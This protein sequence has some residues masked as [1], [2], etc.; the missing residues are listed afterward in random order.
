M[1][2]LIK[3]LV[4]L[5]ETQKAP[6][7]NV[8]VLPHPGQ[9]NSAHV[10]HA[11]LERPHH[12]IETVAVLFS[13]I[14]LEVLQEVCTHRNKS[15]FGPWQKPIDVHG[16]ENRREHLR[17]QR[18]V[19]SQMRE[20]QHHV[21]VVS[22]SI[23]KIGINVDTVL[24]RSRIVSQKVG[25]HLVDGCLLLVLL[26]K[27]HH[28]SGCQH[29]I[30]DLQEVLVYYIL[31]SEDKRDVLILL[32][33]N[34]VQLFQVLHELYLTV[35]FGDGDL[36]QVVARN[37]GSQ[38]GQRLLATAADSNQHGTATLLTNGSVYA[39]QVHHCI[40]KQHEI[41]GLGRVLLVEPCQILVGLS[42]HV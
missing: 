39:H 17:P 6:W 11:E 29:G 15:F 42:G 1:L 4:V 14:Y 32:A 8:H 34:D 7:C 16:A 12:F 38:T 9:V 35:C 2:E 24:L 20:R 23:E 36:E 22:K 40:L 10:T 19:W 21:Q 33:C 27:A 13:G 31:V 37:E 41:H 26:Q 30:H 25:T 3:L 5:D 18:K 28:L